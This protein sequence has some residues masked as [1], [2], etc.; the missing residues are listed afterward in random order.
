VI[1]R[2]DDELIRIRHDRDGRS[3]LTCH[4]LQV[5]VLRQLWTANDF[6]PFEVHN[7]IMTVGGELDTQVTVVFGS[8]DPIDQY[9]RTLDAVQ[10]DGLA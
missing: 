6:P 3:S 4:S 7:D 10:D 9:Q 2:I 8:G 1:S 5:T